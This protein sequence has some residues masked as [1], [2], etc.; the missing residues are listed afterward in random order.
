[1]LGGGDYLRDYLGTLDGFNVSLSCF[2]VFL[3]LKKDLVRE[4]GIE[5]SEVFLETGYDPDAGYQRCLAADV[6]NCGMGVMFYD[7]LYRGA[8]YG[9][10]QTPDNSEPRRAAPASAR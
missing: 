6:E 7:N 3:G 5:D 1:M 2:Q 9:W 8:I 4:A 10:D